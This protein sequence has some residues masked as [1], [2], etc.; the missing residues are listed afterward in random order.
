M[1]D[2]ADVVDGGEVR[3]KETKVALGRSR[4]QILI[5]ERKNERLELPPRHQW[6]PLPRL[7]MPHQVP[8][9][10]PRVLHAHRRLVGIPHRRPP[11]LPH[12]QLHVPVPQPL[13]RRVDGIH[14]RVEHVG[15]VHAGG[16]VVHAGVGLEQS[17]VQG[18]AG[19]PEV[20][21]RVHHELRLR[22]PVE[23][24]QRGEDHPVVPPSEPPRRR[25]LRRGEHAERV[26]TADLDA[27]H[28]GR[29]QGGVDCFHGGE[30][31]GDEG[32]VGGRDDLVAD[33]ETGDAD[34]G[35]E[36]RELLAD[37]VGGGGGG[38]EGGDV[39][40]GNGDS[41]GDGGGGEGGDEGGVG[42]EELDGGDG[43]AL[44]EEGGDVGWRGEVVGD[45]AVVDTDTGDGHRGSAGEE[46]EEE[47]R[48]HLP[49]RLWM[50]GGVG[51]CA[52]L[53]GGFL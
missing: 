38:G 2:D 50:W 49:P 19:E 5:E 25:R 18:A 23:L 42:G 47:E 37:P 21:V 4:L 12:R 1:S 17:I 34:G 26:R 41:E 45:G 28:P 10:Q 7:N 48:R 16:R 3:P 33:G 8:I 11:R 29:L 39:G 31:V 27:A 43:G 40:V 9:V 15:V 52:D 20:R 13:H 14:L 24:Q 30:E 6:R 22:L 36:R 46:K 32:L 44:T 51:S 53:V 35:V